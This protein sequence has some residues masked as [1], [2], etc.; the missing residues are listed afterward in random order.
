M[1]YYLQQLFNRGRVEHEREE[2]TK[3]G[4]GASS[5]WVGGEYEQHSTDCRNLPAEIE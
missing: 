5:G 4:R 1:R 2:S 3:W